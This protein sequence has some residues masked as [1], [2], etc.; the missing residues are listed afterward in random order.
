ML[1][2]LFISLFTNKRPDERLAFLM[3]FINFQTT[4]LYP[5]RS[6]LSVFLINIRLFKWLVIYSKIMTYKSMAQLLSTLKEPSRE[7]KTISA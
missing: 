7:R 2:I 1:E 6:P 5:Y 4:G 3:Q